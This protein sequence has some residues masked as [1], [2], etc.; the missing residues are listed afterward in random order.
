MDR[1]HNQICIDVECN[2]HASFGYVEDG[3]RLYC[4][5]HK[6]DDMVN[7]TGSICRQSGCKTMAS[8]N[9]VGETVK[10]Y[11]SKHKKSMMVRLHY[12]RCRYT[13]SDGVRC[14]T[15]ANYGAETD[16]R[17]TYCAV[18]RLKGMTYKSKSVSVCQYDGCSLVASFNYPGEKQR[19]YC[20]EHRSDGMID[21]TAK[22][23]ICKAEGCTTVA[24]YGYE[25]QKK[26]YCSRH[27][28]RGMVYIRKLKGVKCKFRPVI[29]LPS[30]SPICT[31]NAI[32]NYPGKTSRLYCEDHK[33]E[34]MV[35]VSTK[36][37]CIHDG[38][39]VTASYNYHGQ[40]TRLYCT[41]HK[42]DG[43]IDLTKQPLLCRVDD[44]TNV[45]EYNLPTYKR[46]K[47]CD[48]HKT[49]GMI[50]RDK[51]VRA[52]R[53]R[54]KKRKRNST[55]IQHSGQGQYTF[56]TEDRLYSDE[57]DMQYELL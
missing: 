9:Y 1:V 30:L 41:K 31:K 2:M 35:P 5:R 49:D 8:Y 3:K 50:V 46:P 4:K 44:C 24:S 25:G 10:A 26:E 12:N 45:A 57:A 7:L 37:E 15:A 56:D 32:Y 36:I 23:R 19:L 48:Q 34:G 54:T 11:C 51:T 43:M 33:L 38:C 21:V 47:Y 6:K 18:H 42:K 28:L 39:T 14:S 22:K 27:S 52:V 55:T 40:K 20:S 13:N 17:A 16:T 29:H 53:R